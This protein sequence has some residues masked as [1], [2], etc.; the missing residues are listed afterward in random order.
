MDNEKIHSKHLF[1]SDHPVHQCCGNP[2]TFVAV[3]TTYGDEEPDFDDHYET[4]ND[5]W[6]CLDCDKMKP[7]RRYRDWFGSDD[8]DI[9][10]HNYLEENREEHGE[11]LQV[12]VDGYMACI[13]WD[14]S[15][16][17]FG[18]DGNEYCHSFGFQVESPKEGILSQF[19]MNPPT[20]K[21]ADD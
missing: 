7:S 15:V 10:I 5:Y 19:S 9:E 13:V 12:M 17:V 14:D 3:E 20:F 1:V 8:L 21:M 4:D 11:P 6:L 2:M 16:I 18:Y